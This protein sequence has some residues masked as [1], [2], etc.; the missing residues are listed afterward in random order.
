MPEG[1]RR[2]RAV[3]AHLREP[4][5]RSVALFS[6]ESVQ[7]VDLGLDETDRLCWH[8]CALYGSL[9]SILT[10]RWAKALA[11]PQSAASVF[12]RRA[13]V[14]LSHLFLDRLLRMDRLMAGHPPASLF[15][16]QAPPLAAPPDILK[17]EA[18]AS[19]STVFNQSILCR[20][21]P[22]WGCSVLPWPCEEVFFG[23]VETPADLVNY[24]YSPGSA[25]DKASTRVRR[26]I[27]GRLG[28]VSRAWLGRVPTLSMAYDTGPLESRGLFGRGCFARVDPAALRATDPPAN[29]GLRAAVFG[30]ASADCAPVLRRFL[31]EA[32]VDP[33]G[34]M[35]GIAEA[36]TGFLSEMTPRDLFEGASARL[37]RAKTALGAYGGAPLVLG[38][39]GHTDSVVLIA[40]ARAL[41]IEVIGHQ[42]GGGPGNLDH[43]RYHVETNQC[44][45]DRYITWG[46]RRFSAPSPNPDLQ[47][48]PMPNPW[49]SERARMW[50]RR[51]PG[52]AGADRRYDILFMPDKTLPFPLP[53]MGFEIVCSDHVREQAAELKVLVAETARRG[54]R[55]LHKP[56][57]RLS[58]SILKDTL[59][60]LQELGGEHYERLGRPDKGLSPAL[61][62]SC[63]LVL[64]DRPS[65]GFSEC[66]AAGIP[67]MML[68][69]RFSNRETAGARRTFSD[70]EACGV[71]HRDAR[72]L[73]EAYLAFRR[74]PRAWMEEPLRVRAVQ[75]F[76]R[77]YAWWRP[78]WPKRWR[79]FLDSL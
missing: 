29:S 24:N 25:V 66:L 12:A 46:W 11:I 54:I 14:A 63:K 10:P 79:R 58:A 4:D 60:R 51:L 38:E 7:G 19:F 50:R 21:A 8:Y 18:L 57:N 75:R 16:A 45:C 22:L 55:L 77:R 37:E 47:A 20:L 56:Y 27:A 1:Y 65:S 74:A 41:G 61:V 13:L 70:L 76:C 72:R 30:E 67:T 3:V 32:R 52:T 68:W 53:G 23:A 28:G 39:I 69:T 42:H 64:W 33:E 9:I 26:L 43:L 5:P 49:L 71:I 44:F 2:Q 48:V 34:G 35:A 6:S 78:D 15:V 59:A 73:C 31:H 17:L 40:A 36:F 62:G